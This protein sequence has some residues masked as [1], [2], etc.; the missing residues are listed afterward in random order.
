MVQVNVRRV[1]VLMVNMRLLVVLH[2]YFVR[3]LVKPVTAQLYALRV[4]LLEQVDPC[5][6]TL[7]RVF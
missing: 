6:Y 2:V 5:F 4:G 7:V 1:D 3:F